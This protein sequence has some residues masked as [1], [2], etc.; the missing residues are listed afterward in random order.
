MDRGTTMVRPGPERFEIHLSIDY[1]KDGNVPQCLLSG[2][3][4]G[5]S[6]FGW[7]CMIDKRPKQ[8]ISLLHLRTASTKLVSP[9]KMHTAP[10][11]SD[12]RLSCILR[13]RTN[14]NHCFNRPTLLI[15]FESHPQTLYPLPVFSCTMGADKPLAYLFSAVVFCWCIS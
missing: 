10:P 8:P 6:T 2:M 11:P 13:T 9:S 3:P 4:M 12:L 5:I 15:C 14:L 1:G 7:I